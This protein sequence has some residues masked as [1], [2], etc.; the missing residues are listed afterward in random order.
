M[1][2]HGAHLILLQYLSESAIDPLR[3]QAHTELT[4][5]QTTPRLQQLPIR[6]EQRQQI[7]HEARKVFVLRIRRDLGE[8]LKIVTQNLLGRIGKHLEE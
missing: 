8:E 3:V 1:K 2:H 5:D 6:T 7:H 4:N